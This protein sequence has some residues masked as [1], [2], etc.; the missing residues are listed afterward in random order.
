MDSVDQ[1]KLM[2]GI[3]AGA[4]VEQFPAEKDFT[5][6]ELAL[7]R[8]RDVGAA[9]VLVV[10]GAGGRL[11]HFVANV[12]VLASPD[13]ATMQVRALVGDALMTVIRDRRE[14]HGEPGTLLTL[15]PLGGPA[16]GIRTEGLRYPLRD[17]TL[18]PGSTR[19]VSNVFEAPVATVALDAGVLLAVQPAEGLS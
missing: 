17:E 2:E 7:Q 6:L 18:T 19:G 3:A 10:G 9:D 4:R 12:L 16:R 11:D 5:D 14:L 15:L 8:A 13:Y 1:T